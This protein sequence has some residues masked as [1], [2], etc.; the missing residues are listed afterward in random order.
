M[1]AQTETNLC[2][3]CAILATYDELV[4]LTNGGRYQLGKLQAIG[5]KASAPLPCRLCQEIAL[6][7]GTKADGSRITG[8]RRRGKR[9]KTNLSSELEV[10]TEH[11]GGEVGLPKGELYLTVKANDTSQDLVGNHQPLSNVGEEALF[12]AIHARINDCR[13][14]ADHHKCRENEISRLPTRII[15]VNPDTPGV[16]ARLV[17]TTG[18][19]A[20]YLCL[21]YCWGGPQ[22]ITATKAS[23]PALE[24]S[25][26]VHQL[27]GALQDA[28]QATRQMGFRYLWVDALCI[29]QDDAEN[30]QSEISQMG[31][32]YTNAFAVIV[33]A[34]SAASTEPFLYHNRGL[35]WRQFLEGCPVQI[36]PP[37]GSVQSLQLVATR[38]VAARRVGQEPL[39]TRAW[40]LQESMLARRKVVFS[41]YD[42]FVECRTELGLTP[43]RR[44]F[45]KGYF[46]RNPSPNLL[47]DFGSPEKIGRVWSQILLCYTE[48]EMTNP[49]DRLNAFQGITDAIRL[50]FDGN[51]HFGIA[52]AWPVTLGWR[53]RNQSEGRSARAP[54]WS[55]G[56]LNCP[57][58]L[59]DPDAIEQASTNLDN[60]CGRRLIVKGSVIYGDKWQGEHP[61]ASPAHD[62][63]GKGDGVYGCI[64]LDVENT[65]PDPHDRLYLRLLEKR[66]TS[67]GEVALVLE[68]VEPGTY[69]RVGI[70]YG[71]VFNGGWGQ[72]QDV[73]VV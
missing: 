53:A 38:N 33:A 20:E 66:G 34:G 57:V 42:V 18:E 73:I 29:V 55:W 14:R 15:D 51:F 58:K 31:S 27:G 69:R 62:S 24:K 59:V 46:Y 35:E 28:I 10:Y 60:S 41:T 67:R 64:S 8:I 52:L 17:R 47:L 23:L 45:V 48:R 37:S 25:I 19:H 56:C 65:L 32:I 13:G 44:S 61:P 43:L 72:A 39:D 36:K 22:K 16:D 4:R 11:E 5:E 21:S 26:P 30:I 9:P 68:R 40:A 12:A 1:T 7:L 49:E 3:H 63:Q 70:Y 50:R 2:S 6:S 54:T 71:R